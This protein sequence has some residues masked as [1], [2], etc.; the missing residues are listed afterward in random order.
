MATIRSTF[1][2]FSGATSGASGVTSVTAGTGLTGGTITSS[3]TIAKNGVSDFDGGQTLALPLT[4]GGSNVGTFTYLPTLTAQFDVTNNNRV[5][6]GV[7]SIS[8]ATRV[9]I[10]GLNVNDTISVTGRFTTTCSSGVLTLEPAFSGVF[11]GVTPTFVG[12]DVAC[13][14]TSQNIDFTITD[15]RVMVTNDLVPSNSNSNYL[16]FQYDYTGS[17]GTYRMNFMDIDVNSIHQ[18]MSDEFKKDFGFFTQT[19]GPSNNAVTSI[20]AGDGLTASPNPIV[21]TG[22]IGEKQTSVLSLDKVNQL[23]ARVLQLEFFLSPR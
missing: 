13:D 21:G 14:G 22:T 5:S 9:G 1:G 7:K 4:T 2:I 10:N 11:T 8:G 17:G 12:N 19:Q 3:G 15:F 18:K 16:G 20:T 23:S 6:F